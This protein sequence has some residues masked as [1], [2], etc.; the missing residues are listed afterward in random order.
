MASCRSPTNLKSISFSKFCQTIRQ[1][2]LKCQ[3]VGDFSW[4]A[5]LEDSDSICLLRSV[6]QGL[7][8]MA[9]CDGNGEG[10]CFYGKVMTDFWSYLNCDRGSSI[11]RCQWCSVGGHKVT[12][13]ILKNHWLRYTC[14]S[15]VSVNADTF[16]KDSLFSTLKFREMLKVLVP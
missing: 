14:I 1:Q 15:S 5:I 2:R 3:T 4:T 7:L 9:Y 10:I 11:V 13:F 8:K 16:Q 6:S 12:V